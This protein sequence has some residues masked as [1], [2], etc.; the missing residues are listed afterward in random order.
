MRETQ[1]I[2]SILY[3]KEV[4]HVLLSDVEVY[5]IK[6]WYFSGVEEKVSL[7]HVCTSGPLPGPNL[8][9]KLIDWDIEWSLCFWVG[10]E[11]SVEP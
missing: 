9:N 11:T 7:G 1:I 2:V 10:L 4:M 6:M 5:V 8:R 3:K